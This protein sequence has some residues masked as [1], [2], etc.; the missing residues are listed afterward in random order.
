L[1]VVY[2]LGRRV[3]GHR[4]RTY[5]CVTSKSFVSKLRRRRRR[6]R[7]ELSALDRIQCGGLGSSVTRLSQRLSRRRRTLTHGDDDPIQLATRSRPDW[8][9]LPRWHSGQVASLRSR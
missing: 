4:S 1:A 3:S 7:V 2:F 8:A 9:L 6:R 5:I